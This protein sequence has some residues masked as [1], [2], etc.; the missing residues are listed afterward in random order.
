MEET[1]VPG[2]SRYEELARWLKRQSRR[3]DRVQ[4]SFR[5][6]EEIIGT[7]L[8]PSARRHRA[9]WANDTVSH[10]QSQ[11]WLSAD[12]RVAN[13]NMS[14]EHV[15]FA[16]V[17]ERE[18]AYIA[19]FSALMANINQT[20]KTFKLSSPNGQAWFI[21]ERIAVNKHALGSFGFSFTR[22]ADFRVELYIDSGDAAV[23]QQI[24]NHLQQSLGGRDTVALLGEKISWE[25]LPGKRASRIA[26][27]HPGSIT[28][29]PD[30]LADLRRWAVPVM[31]KFYELFGNF[32]P[33]IQQ[34]LASDNP[35]IKDFFARNA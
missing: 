31:L 28:S 23:N 29:P 34:L 6:V 35:I 10:V 24:F 9:W 3:E 20:S 2:E 25:D 32:E 13:I 22:D 7:D 5:Q 12:W 21:V 19:F 16:R 30:E 15:V 18:N 27:Y 14:D 11:S 4:L 17:R 8:P 1:P 26:I 33:M